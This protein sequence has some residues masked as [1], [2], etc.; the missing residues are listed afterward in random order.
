MRALSF[1]LSELLVRKDSP[2][3]MTWTSHSYELTE[4]YTWFRGTYKN[5]FSQNV[6]SLMGST[7]FPY[8]RKDLISF[9]N[10]R[11]EDDVLESPVSALSSI[12]LGCTAIF[13]SSSYQQGS[14][15]PIAATLRHYDRQW[16][17]TPMT[18]TDSPP[19]I[20]Q[21]G[22]YSLDSGDHPVLPAF[23]LPSTIEVDQDLNLME[24]SA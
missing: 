14:I 24:R 22:G 1:L 2:R 20:L 18:R 21:N 15:L 7:K 4:I 17:R 9:G 3:D 16:S 12:E 23:T 19:T 8:L 13:N 11:I 6:I 5:R 10:Y